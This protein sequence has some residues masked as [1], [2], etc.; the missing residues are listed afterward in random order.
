M[1]KLP[2]AHLHVQAR[3]SVQEC[4]VA[5]VVCMHAQHLHMLSL[6]TCQ[7]VGVHSWAHLQLPILMYLSAGHAG[8]CQHELSRCLVWVSKTKAPLRSDCLDTALMTVPLW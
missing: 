5:G 1:V 7:H 6:D 4:S 8:Q 3:V 2:W